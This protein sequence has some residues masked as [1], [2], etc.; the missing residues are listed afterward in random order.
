MPSSIQVPTLFKNH[1][2]IPNVWVKFLLS[3]FFNNI[4][5]ISRISPIA[6]LVN[7]YSWSGYMNSSSRNLFMYIFRISIIWY[8]VPWFISQHSPQFMFH[9]KLVPWN[10][11]L[12]VCTIQSRS[13][14]LLGMYMLIQGISSEDASSLNLC[15]GGVVSKRRVPAQHLIFFT[16]V[17]MFSLSMAI[18]C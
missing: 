4:I 11:F 10:G 13:I 16:Q 6:K 3:W 5:L 8:M 14:C 17:I 15:P 9:W 12:H 2:L 7:F 1:S 18:V